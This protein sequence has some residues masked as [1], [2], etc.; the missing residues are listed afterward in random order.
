MTE[1]RWRNVAIVLA[2][3]LV[4]LVV[5]SFVT[6]FPAG[7]RTRLRAR[8]RRQPGRRPVGRPSATSSAAAGS[9]G[10]SATASPSASAKASPT[11]SASGTANAGVAQVTF[12]GFKLDATTDPAGKARTFTFKTDGPG[13]VNAKLGEEEPTGHDQ[14]LPQGRVDCHGDLPDWTSGELTGTTSAKG[15]TTFV[16]TRSGS[17]SP[18]RPST[19][20]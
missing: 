12:S 4:L 2:V 5:S 15:Q 16:V 6:S 18:P 20:A 14:V 3:V 7:P 13:N 10:P 8:R 17:A 9:A 19:S 1:E 11:A